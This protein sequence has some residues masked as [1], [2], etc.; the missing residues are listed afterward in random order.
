M[1]TAKSDISVSHADTDT[2]DR[3]VKTK[4]EGE[5]NPT[6]H[7]SVIDGMN[8]KWINDFVLLASTS[9]YVHG[10]GCD[11]NVSKSWIIGGLVHSR[12]HAPVKLVNAI[13]V[14]ERAGTYPIT[15]PAAACMHDHVVYDQYFIRRMW[16]WMRIMYVSVGHSIS[17]SPTPHSFSNTYAAASRRLV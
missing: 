1:Y 11:V 9:L 2:E 6:D 16:S 4:S 15:S 10:N 3:T 14:D 8:T 7:S 13:S 17:L 12:T 5:Q